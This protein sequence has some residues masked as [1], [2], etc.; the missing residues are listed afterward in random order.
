MIGNLY[1]M[2]LP[3][4]C[5]EVRPCEEP[6]LEP[7]GGSMERPG[8]ILKFMEMNANLRILTEINGGTPPQ[9]EGTKRLPSFWAHLNRG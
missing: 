5:T 8:G 2:Q 4:P 3:M 9:N 6:F 1:V 7:I